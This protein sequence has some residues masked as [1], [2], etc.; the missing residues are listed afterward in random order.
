MRKQDQQL[1]DLQIL[2]A[3]PAG[4]VSLKEF[5]RVAAILPDHALPVMHRL[6]RST[7]VER[8]EVDGC[9]QYRRNPEYVG[10]PSLFTV[11]ARRRA[12]RIVIKRAIGQ[13][14][15][16]GTLT[17]IRGHV[18]EYLTQADMQPLAESDRRLL[19]R[20]LRQANYR[21]IGKHSWYKQG[22]LTVLSFAGSQFVPFEHR[23]KPR[24]RK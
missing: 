7:H 5:C 13:M 11:R 1:R 20:T 3:F 16:R 24:S 8:R 6:V 17:E 10:E 23:R 14:P 19:T 21:P 2:D 22:F 18:N 9:I 15:L 12:R 4:W